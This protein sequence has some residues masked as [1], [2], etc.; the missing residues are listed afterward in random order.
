MS[1]PQRLCSQASIK[2]HEPQ[3]ERK[4]KAEEERRQRW[5]H[6]HHHNHQKREIVFTLRPSFWFFLNHKPFK[7]IQFQKSKAT[8]TRNGSSLSSLSQ[9]PAIWV[10]LWTFRQKEAEA[11]EEKPVSYM[12][13]IGMY[14]ECKYWQDWLGP[15][16]FAVF[17][18]VLKSALAR[19]ESCIVMYVQKLWLKFLLDE[20][21]DFG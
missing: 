8:N 12:D 1:Q 9:S 7:Y 14:L 17:E 6:N 19:Q 2:F 20:N 15:F 13:H 21:I 10:T 18:I 5:C 3:C 11:A 16:A 4:A